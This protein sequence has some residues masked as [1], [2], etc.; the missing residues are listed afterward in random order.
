RA[1]STV[2]FL[3]RLARAMAAARPL[4]PPPITR[5]S[6]MS[7]TLS[8]GR[9]A[10]VEWGQCLAVQASLQPGWCSSHDSF[11]QQRLR[12]QGAGRAHDSAAGVRA[13][14]A[15]PQL[16]DRRAVARPAR[17]RP[18]KRE[19]LDAE[20]AVKDVPFGEPVFLLEI[21]RRQNVPVQDARLEPGG[22]LLDDVAHGVAERLAL[23]RPRLGP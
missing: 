11:F 23:R 5:A 18:Q 1:S 20:L 10:E 7:C 6:V 22:E 12:A 21:P 8:E 15:H 3:P 14:R 17:R 9:Q 16:V 19:L 2:T 13:A 4:W